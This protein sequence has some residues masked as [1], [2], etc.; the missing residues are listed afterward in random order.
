[1]YRIITLL[2]ALFQCWC[3]FFDFKIYK[4]KFVLFLSFNEESLKDINLIICRSRLLT[5]VQLIIFM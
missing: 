1:M 3:N 2:Y 4:K 5:N